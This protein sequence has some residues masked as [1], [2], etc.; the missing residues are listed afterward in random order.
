MALYL[1]HSEIDQHRWNQAIQQASYPTVFAETD[2]LDIASP[3]WCAIVKDDYEF[4]MPL[5]V[6]KKWVFSY[7]FHPNFFPPYGIFSSKIITKELVKEFVDAIPK[8]YLQAD[9]VFNPTCDFDK[10]FLTVK[11]KRTSLLSL[12]DSYEH[13]YHSFAENCKRNIK[14]SANFDLK[15][16][17]HVDIDNIITLFQNNRGKSKNVTL[18][19]IDYA[20]LQKTG[21][22]LQKKGL[23]E[24]IVV[25]NAN[26]NLL[27]GALFAKDHRRI[28]FLFSGRDKIFSYKRA[29]FFLVN[30]FIKTHE[31][32]DL[33]LDFHGSMDENLSRFYEGFGANIEEFYTTTKHV[34]FLFACYKSVYICSQK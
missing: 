14:K 2:F 18:S 11:K 32:Q 13:I 7:I 5:P 6:R 12:S 25:E 24:I 8:K 27:A 23:L 21:Q 15:I 31:N 28:R 30:Y 26:K 34:N 22:L 4:V 33:I 9:L 1:K 16:T 10:F 29:M 17:H 20:I 19:A 3:Q